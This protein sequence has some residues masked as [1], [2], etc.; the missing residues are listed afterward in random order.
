MGPTIDA[1]EDK[2]V[3]VHALTNALYIS[4]LREKHRADLQRLTMM[5]Q[6]FKTSAFFVLATAQ[7]LGRA[8]SSILKKGSWLK[9]VVLMVVATWG[10]LLFTDGPHEKV[11]SSF[12]LTCIYFAGS[13]LHTFVMY[14]GPHLA[15]FTI[16]AVQ[17]GRVDLKS[18]PYDTILL[19]RSP[20]WL[21]KD[22][23]E[24]GPPIYQETIPFSKILQEVYLEAVL[25]GIGTSLGELP[26]YFL[27]RAARMSGRT[28]DELEDFNPSI[29]EGSP[30]LTLHQAKRWLM[31]HSQ[32][33]SFTLILLL[34]SVPNPLFDLAGM[35]CGQ[36]N[37]PF[38]KFFLATLIGKAIVKVCI[39]TTLVITLCNNQLLDLVEKRLIW[40]FGNIPGVASVLP[41]LVAKLKTA[42]DKFLSAHL[43]A[44]ASIAVKGKW[45]LSFTLIWNTVVWLMVI[46]FVIQ[47]VTS[48]AQGYL[49]TQQELEISKKLSETELSA[50]E[51]SSG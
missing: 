12:K 36:F 41:S 33:L 38:W 43:A 16:K 50:S 13:G 45:N 40:A 31:S 51:P 42:K 14:L 15:V 22:C 29:S 1:G 19:K 44:S 25:W 30:S 32:R 23:L 2:G 9:I 3:S 28:I 11:S 21:E 4:E 48:T 6:P 37:V 49:R 35:L 27:S 20:S 5:S 17:C 24:F 10:L 46:N 7:S 34:A 47:I 8:C 39:Q 18:A 26:P